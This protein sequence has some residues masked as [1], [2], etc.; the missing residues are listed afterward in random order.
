[1]SNKTPLDDQQLDA[2]LEQLPKSIEPEDDLWP[3]IAAKLAPKAP[4]RNAPFRYSIAASFIVGILGIGLA[5]TSQWQNQQLKAQITE[6]EDQ[7]TAASAFRTV[8]VAQEQAC[9]PAESGQL[10]IQ[11]NLVIIES[12]LKQIEN[13]L[14][15]APGDPVL[16]KRYLDLSKQQMNLIHRANTIAL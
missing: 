4:A 7:P 5:V 6:L 11:E 8:N 3:G 14:K 10:V 15:N 13:A 9:P 12:A 16:N 1:M 2:L